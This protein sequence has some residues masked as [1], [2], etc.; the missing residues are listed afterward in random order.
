M[1]STPTAREAIEGSSEGEFQLM[2]WALI[3]A[4]TLIFGSAFLWI[5]LS[6]RSFSPGVV[7]AVRVALG[8]AALATLKGSRVRIDRSDYK[9]LAA[10]GIFG[11]AVP[12]LLF[13]MAEERISSALTGMLISAVPLATAIVA[14]IV[15][16][17]LPHKTRVLGLA[18]GLS[19]VAMLGGSEILTGGGEAVGIAMVLGALVCYA[20]ASMLYAPL[21]QHYGAIPVVMWSLAV[22]T[23]VLLPAIPFG[24]RASDISAISVVALLILGIIGTGLARS[25][26]VTAM[27]RLGTVRSSTA[28]YFVPGVALVI[29]VLVLGETVRPMQV[30]GVT[31]AVLGGYLLAKAKQSVQS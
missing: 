17:K 22:A 20:I 6:L 3:A 16:R 13:A 14:A 12:A 15:T 11:Q 27:G 24:Y 10:A 5:S 1:S 23:V 29:G 30:L 19:G 28:G 26:L 8:A 7:A 25:L 2:D 31:V 18:V 9:S 21:Q 4:V